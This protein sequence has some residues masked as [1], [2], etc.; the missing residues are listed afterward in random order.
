M[1]NEQIL[2]LKTK[3]IQGAETYFKPFLPETMIY[4]TIL[5]LLLED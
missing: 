4:S 2:D 1:Y 5:K 3:I